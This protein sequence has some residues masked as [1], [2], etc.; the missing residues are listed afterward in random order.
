M[1]M[2][3]YGGVGES[4]ICG[5]P[6][7]GSRQTSLG[8]YMVKRLLTGERWCEKCVEDPR[9]ALLELA[10]CDLGDEGSASEG[11]THI[12]YDDAGAK[13]YC[14]QTLTWQ[15]ISVRLADFKAG[16]AV[17]HWNGPLWCNGCLRNRP[18]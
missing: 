9:L 16:P 10:D 13:L 3:V 15:M 11:V 12:S 5:A 14:G 1:I 6:I 2:H 8:A 17:G 18:R 4:N 7:V